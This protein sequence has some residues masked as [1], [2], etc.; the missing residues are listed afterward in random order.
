[1]VSLEKGFFEVK[2]KEDSVFA[3]TVKKHLQGF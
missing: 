3:D 2:P 1:M